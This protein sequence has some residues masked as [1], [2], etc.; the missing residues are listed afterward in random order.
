M[1][2]SIVIET[3]DGALVEIYNSPSS[4]GGVKTWEIG[5]G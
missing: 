4:Y 3:K 1:C 5:G 2:K